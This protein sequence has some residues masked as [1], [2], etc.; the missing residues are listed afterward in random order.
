MPKPSG[1]SQERA[2]APQTAKF[3]EGE[4]A[5]AHLLFEQLTAIYERSQPVLRAIGVAFRLQRFPSTVNG[6]WCASR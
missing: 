6:P 5:P 4:E 1:P 2:A 3:I